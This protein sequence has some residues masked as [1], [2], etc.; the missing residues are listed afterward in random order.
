MMKIMMMSCYMMEMKKKMKNLMMIMITYWIAIQKLKVL[1]PVMMWCK[2]RLENL[3][4]RMKKKKMMIRGKM[5]M[6]KR[7]KM[8]CFRR[9]SH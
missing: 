2:Y 8:T 6:T 5:M 4:R 1:K 3:V 9:N 7:T